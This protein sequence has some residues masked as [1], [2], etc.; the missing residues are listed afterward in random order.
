MFGG[1]LAK[2]WLFLYTNQWRSLS[3]VSVRM[4]TSLRWGNWSPAE[5]VSPGPDVES[6]GAIWFQEMENWNMSVLIPS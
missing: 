1:F 3:Q 6:G 5:A 2:S 4:A